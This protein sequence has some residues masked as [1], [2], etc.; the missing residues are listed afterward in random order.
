MDAVR[1]L[2]QVR[3]EENVKLAF[4]YALSD[5]QHCDSYFD[6]IEIE[7]MKLYEDQVI[8]EVLESLQFPEKFQPQV[9]YAYYLSKN[10]LCYRRM[11]YIPFKDLIIRYAF[12]IVLANHLD[13]TLSKCCFANRRAKD[14]QAKTF[15]LEDYYNISFK[16][17]RQWQKECGQ[18]FNVLIRTDISAFYDS[19][20]HQYL[21]ESIAQ[22]LCISN[23]SDFLYLFKKLLCVPVIS[24]SNKINKIQAHPKILQ[25]GLTIG[26]NLEGFLANLYL[27]DVDQAMECA[28]VEFG[29]YN[30]DIRIFTNDRE[31]ALS[32]IL[33]LQESLLTKGLNLNSSKTKIAENQEEIEKLRTKW[34]DI[35]FLNDNFFVEDESH[36]NQENFMEMNE[37]QKNI[38]FDNLDNDFDP[39][40]DLNSNEDAKKFCQFIGNHNILKQRTPE[41]LEKLETI[42]TRWQGSSKHASWLVVQ[43]IS[44]KKISENTK[45]KAGEVLFYVLK[46]SEAHYYTKYRL[47]HHLL[48][49]R[50]PKK[51]AALME[52]TESQKE[53]LKSILI[54]FLKKPAFELNLISLYGLKNLGDSYLALE[55][56][57]EDYMIR[58]LGSPIMTALSYMQ[59][60]DIKTDQS[61]SSP[62]EKMSITSERKT[63]EGDDEPDERWEFY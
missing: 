38:D 39:D 26:N 61:K 21:I 11:I 28:G 35:S 31:T 24:Y 9:A 44:D 17:F 42:L 51:M 19:I 4:R 8:A 23:D 54:D 33:I 56:Y 1:L 59:D 10:N 43:S 20:S 36:E 14:K 22:Q 46:N 52:L 18:K 16:K 63:D 62:A 6:S 49:K 32:Q 15:L 41:H 29:R 53:N 2:N 57:V 47:V 60:L 58:P 50:G 7:Y 27:K 25:Q 12:V 13:K 37:V 48:K 34:Y 40:L 55:K 3:N 45:K 30:D 5:R